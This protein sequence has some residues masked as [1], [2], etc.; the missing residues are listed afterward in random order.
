[1]T[2]AEARAAMQLF[3]CGSTQDM[4]SRLGI[5]VNTFKT[6]IKAHAKMNT[7]RPAGLLRLML[8]LGAG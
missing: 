1:M 2:P 8:S 6:Q 7:N 5:S 3:A 4:A